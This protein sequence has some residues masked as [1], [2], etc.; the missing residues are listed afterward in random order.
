[1]KKHSLN[2]LLLEDDEDYALVFM[3]LV[4]K[5]S[6][7]ITW[8]QDLSEFKPLLEN[9]Q[10]YDLILMDL[11]LESETSL[12]AIGHARKFQQQAKIVIVTGYASIATTVEAIKQGADDYLP[13]PVSLDEIFSLYYNGRKNGENINEKPL[14]AKRLEWEHIQ[15][16]LKDCDGNISRTAEQLN[17]HRRTLQRKLQKRPSR[18]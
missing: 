1:M 14:S 4:K 6:H 12:Q 13:K 15:R 2:I 3:R 9:G 7:A 17:M 11:K 10:C 5:R 8:A 18:E 16:V